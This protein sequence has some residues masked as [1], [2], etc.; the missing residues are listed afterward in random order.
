MVVEKMDAVNL[1][2]YTLFAILKWVYLITAARA[3]GLMIQGWREEEICTSLSFLLLK[4]VVAPVLK[5]STDI[6]IANCK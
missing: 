4:V 3:Y 6:L 1:E 2:S 5:S